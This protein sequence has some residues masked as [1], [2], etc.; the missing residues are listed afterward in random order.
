MSFSSSE[1]IHRLQN[2]DPDEFEQFIGD[3]WE[4]LGWE[5]EVTTE[6]RDR[7]ID[8]IAEQYHPYQQ[9]ILIQAKRYR[10]DNR[11]G[12]PEIREYSSLR[13][14]EEDV[15]QVLIVTTSEFTSDARAIASELNVKCINGD[16]LAQ[17]VKE[18]NAMELV[19]TT[20]GGIQSSKTNS[21]ER[22]AKPGEVDRE[23]AGSI[24][25]IGDDV[26]AELLGIAR[27]SFSA[28]SDI[29]REK[30]NFDGLFVALNLHTRNLQDGVWLAIE[31]TEEIDIVDEAGSWHNPIPLS[32]KPLRKGWQTHDPEVRTQLGPRD[33]DIDIQIQETTKYL[34]AVNLDLIRDLSL[35][36][37]DR[38]DIEIDL[39]NADLADIP[40]LPDG[41]Q[42]SLESTRGVSIHTN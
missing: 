8:V 9:K 18:N 16:L 13:R 15:D 30:M 23:T 40:C 6:S 1:V 20:T 19:E 26:V 31:N 10:S 36:K 5:T 3:L 41:L 21:L 32:E 39:T 12:S 25:G 22:D 4:R 2:L 14:Q 29:S 28:E 42:T 33:L 7:G 24:R 35:I 34:L 17:L 37:I 38:Y 27:V 11:V